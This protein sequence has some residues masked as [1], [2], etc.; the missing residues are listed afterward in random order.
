MF[1]NGRACACQRAVERLNFAHARANAQVDVTTEDDGRPLEGWGVRAV[2]GGSSQATFGDG[3][4][5]GLAYGAPPPRPRA[6]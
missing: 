1:Q 5:G 2:I 6:H 4:Y 3:N